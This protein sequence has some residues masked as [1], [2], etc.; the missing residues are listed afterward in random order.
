[1]QLYILSY[2]VYM[3]R[4]HCI[5]LISSRFVG[6]CLVIMSVIFLRVAEASTFF[7]REY[8]DKQ[9]IFYRGN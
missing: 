8:R 9:G 5:S 1:M 7:P 4:V 6:L 2:S 3:K